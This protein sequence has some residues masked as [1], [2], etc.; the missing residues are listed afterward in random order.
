MIE[1]MEAV[2]NLVITGV[3]CGVMIVDAMVSDKKDEKEKTDN[4]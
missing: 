1:L 3:K 2:E 4:K